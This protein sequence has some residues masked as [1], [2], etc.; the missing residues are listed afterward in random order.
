MVFCSL[1]QVQVS[2]LCNTCH[3]VCYVMV[4][5]QIKEKGFSVSM[6]PSIGFHLPFLSKMRVFGLDID[7]VLA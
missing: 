4:L 7:Q 1:A 3:G 6:A 5:L 2:D